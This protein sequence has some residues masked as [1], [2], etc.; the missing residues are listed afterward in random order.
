MLLATGS[1]VGLAL[2]AAG[3]LAD[4]GVAPRVVALPCWELFEE[5]DQ[6]YRDEVLPPDVTARV[7]V[8]AASPLA[9]SA[10]SAI[11]ASRGGHRPVRRLGAPAE[12]LYRECVV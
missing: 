9:G 10:R 2:E 12:V 7:A 6:S 8:E 1:E 3:S 4:A 11:A 5:Q